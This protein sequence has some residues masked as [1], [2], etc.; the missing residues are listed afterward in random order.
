MF[1]QINT[2]LLIS[3]EKKI[4]KNWKLTMS[5]NSLKRD[6]I[7]WCIENENIRIQWN[8]NASTVICYNYNKI[9]I[10]LHKKSNEYPFL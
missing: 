4:K 2:I 5:I 7:L 8:F 3:I 1:D 9:T 10:S 6:K